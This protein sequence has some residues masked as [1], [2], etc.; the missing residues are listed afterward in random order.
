MTRGKSGYSV[1]IGTA[2]N[3]LTYAAGFVGFLSVVRYVGIVYSFAFACLFS[4]ALFFDYHRRYAIPRG[5]LSAMLVV[6]I[7]LNSLRITLDDL[8]TPVVEALLVLISVKFLEEKKTR[9]YLQIYAIATFLL[10]GSALMTLDLQFLI[11]LVILS[12]L[13]PLCI[14][15]LTFYSEDS[16]MMLTNKDLT[17]IM[18]KALLIPLVSIPVTALMFV[19]LPR[20]GYPMLNFLSRG[21]AS[22]GFSD[23]VKLGDV[24][25]IQENAV[26]ILRVETENIDDSMLYWRGIVLD[27][28]DGTSWSNPNRRWVKHELL[29]FTGRKV[30]QTVYLEPY[31]SKYLFAL[32]KPVSIDYRGSE[33]SGD[34]TAAADKN[35]DRRVKYGAVS[36]L[37]NITSQEQIDKARYLQ[38]PHR[39][40]SRIEAIVHGLAPGRSDETR[41]EAM[42]R[43]LKDGQFGYSLKNLPVSDRPLEDFLLTYKYGNCEYFASSMAVML[44]LAGIPARLV[45]GY[46]GGYYNN[47]GGYY[48]VTQNNAHVWV[49]AYIGKGWIRMD[50]TPGSTGAFTSSGKTGFL[51]QTKLFLDSLNYYWNAMIIGYDLNKQ[52]YILVRFRNIIQSPKIDISGLKRYGF[53]VSVVLIVVIAAGAALHF[54]IRRKSLEKTVIDNFM[55]TMEKMGYKRAESQ[56]LREFAEGVADPGLRK[57]ALRFVDGF[58]GLLYRDRKMTSDDLSR[59]KRLIHDL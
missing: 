1:S 53:H 12:F 31:E 30:A 23:S 47:I 19:I 25:T 48:L 59:L 15:L 54:S 8:A 50:P 44:R 9:D 14:V 24:S 21:G 27:Y 7:G 6:F 28:F 17:R 41:A 32:D 55:D 22:A 20:T 51:L 16:R 57:K 4:L 29:G 49:E 56:G 5:I 18:S 35:I 52:M 43:Y 36:A 10:T 11:N 46:R 13:L 42:L 26:V 40:L 2:L 37:S 39:D 34:L 38:L 33:I 3:G 45:A 58:E